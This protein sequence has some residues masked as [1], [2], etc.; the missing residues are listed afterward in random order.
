MR[1]P[2][3]LPYK[4]RPGSKDWPVLNPLIESINLYEGITSRV[5]IASHDRGVTS[6]PE[7]ARYRG[8]QIVSWRQAR[9]GDSAFLRVSPIVVEDK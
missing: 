6:G 7:Y 8:F 3:R 1:Q 2:M 4:R 5:I 9:A